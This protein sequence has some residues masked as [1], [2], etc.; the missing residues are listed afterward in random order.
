MDNSNSTLN[1]NKSEPLGTAS[2]VSHTPPE[3]SV[4]PLQKHEE[5]I[6][7]PRPKFSF[8]KIYKKFIPFF[9]LIVL[10][11]PLAYIFL[12]N[13]PFSKNPTSQKKGEIVWWELGGNEAVMQKLID[14]YVAGNPGAKIT[15]ITQSETDFGERLTN[16]L[17]EGRGPD[18]F[19]IHNSWKPAMYKYMDVLT[20]NAYS[21]DS[22]IKEYYPVITKD[23]ATPEGIVALPS[24]FDAITL[25]INDDIFLRSASIHPRTWDQ[26]VETAI[27]LTTRDSK[28][29]I[30]Q[31]GSSMG[32]TDNVD[33]W[34]E[35]VALLMLQ[36][37][38]DLFSPSGSNSNEAMKTFTEFFR[39]HKTWDNTLPDSTTAFAEGK[40]A[41]YFAPGREV[42]KIKE[43]NPSLKFRS[44][45]LPQVR[46]DDPSEPDVSYATYWARAVS[47]KSKDRELAWSFLIYL[48]QNDTFDKM[49]QY[50]KDIG[51]VPPASAKIFYKDKLI[52]DRYYGS[53]IA[54]APVASSW[55]LADKTYDGEKGINSVVNAAYKKVIDGLS[56]G[57]GTDYVKTLKNLSSEIRTG[58]SPY[59]VS[60]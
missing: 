22:F 19:S 36:N 54:L 21:K 56:K 18:I 17:K 4:P 9:S 47:N 40:V 32:L 59:G 16:S 25:F 13:N 60:K 20:E 5:F 33:Y 10:L 51:L 45:L 31:S 55:Y 35:I 49:S 6:Y 27:N 8:G 12:K 53:I 11:I 29:T 23:L 7:R 43:I 38:S 57:G 24:E 48:S 2:A 44:V 46:K 39:N 50:Y 52:N 58:L 34:Q 15:L 30:L 28:S 41:M 26:F 3:G 1:Q 14:E 42:N 37:K